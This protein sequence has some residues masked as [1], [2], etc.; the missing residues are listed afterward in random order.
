MDSEG[1]SGAT[2][3]PE[4]EQWLEDHVFTGLVAMD[5]EKACALC[6]IT[7]QQASSTEWFAERLMRYS[8]LR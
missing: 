8:P 6:D 2:P 5:E 4:G 7:V 3:L 1:G